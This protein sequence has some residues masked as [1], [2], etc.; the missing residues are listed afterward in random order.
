MYHY[1]EKIDFCPF[2]GATQR[3]Q[4]THILGSNCEF[5]RPAGL[6]G[7]G[8]NPKS[9]VRIQLLKLWEA[10]VTDFRFICAL[11]CMC[12]KCKRGSVKLLSKY[13]ASVFKH[14]EKVLDEHATCI[15]ASCKGHGMAI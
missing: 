10:V 8:V 13:C 15:E 2:I 7:S 9:L 11:H 4:I 3:G 1:T 6:A 14:F 12:S 5:F